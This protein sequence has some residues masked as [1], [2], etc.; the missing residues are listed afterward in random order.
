VDDGPRR[1]P[2]A[3]PEPLLYIA[4][5]ISRLD[6]VALQ[7]VKRDLGGLRLLMDPDRPDQRR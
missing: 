4:E 5:I 2:E 7:E 3:G 1:L 6:V